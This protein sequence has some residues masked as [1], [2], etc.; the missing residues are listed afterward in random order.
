MDLLS[1]IKE[2]DFKEMSKNLFK[3]RTQNNAKDIKQYISMYAF[4]FIGLIVLYPVIEYFGFMVDKKVA[5]AIFYNMS[6]N[7]EEATQRGTLVAVIIHF[8]LVVF[9]MYVFKI[10]V[11]D[12]HKEDEHKP[13]FWTALSLLS[14]AFIGTITI[15]IFADSFAKAESRMEKEKLITE[16]E[17]SREQINKVASFV[18][19]SAKSPTLLADDVKYLFRQDSIDAVKKHLSKVKEVAPEANRYNDIYR[20]NIYKN[21]WAKTY[22]DNEWAD[23]IASYNTMINTISEARKTYFNKADN[24]QK[25]IVQ[26]QKD[27]ANASI[28]ITKQ[29]IALKAETLEDMKQDAHLAGWFIRV[30]STLFQILS[31]LIS[32]ALNI[33]YRDGDQSDP[34]KSTDLQTEAEQVVLQLVTTGTKGNIQLNSKQKSRIRGWFRRGYNKKNSNNWKL[35]EYAEQYMKRADIFVND[36]GKGS[37]EFIDKNGNKL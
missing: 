26:M 10:W 16:M 19:A 25:E 17:K 12:L 14:I 24:E 15:N 21:K 30:Q 6:G 9:G 1:K 31:L 18:S 20:K 2:F 5:T 29:R 13:I 7:L 11:N 23:T 37:I 32:M 33:L 28:E 22:R 36:L 8:I 34:N 3:K 27:N 4:L 35:F